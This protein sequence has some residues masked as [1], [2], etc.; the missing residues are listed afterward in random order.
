MRL[1]NVTG[2][3]EY[4]ADSRFVVHNPEECKG[5]WNEVFGNNQPIRI[6]IGM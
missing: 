6:E 5:K 3:R 1:R 4:I 2:S